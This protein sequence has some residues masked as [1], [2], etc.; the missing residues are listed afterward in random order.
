MF[1]PHLWKNSFGIYKYFAEAVRQYHRRFALSFYGEQQRNESRAYAC[2][3]LFG[4]E[5]KEEVM[6]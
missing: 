2:M 5:K 4:G 6:E 1:A 3:D